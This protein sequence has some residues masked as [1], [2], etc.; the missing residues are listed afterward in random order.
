VAIKIRHQKQVSK[1]DLECLLKSDVMISESFT[2]NIG[3]H[4]QLLFLLKWFKDFCLHP[5]EIF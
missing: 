5:Y 4:E 1:I 3:A 2:V